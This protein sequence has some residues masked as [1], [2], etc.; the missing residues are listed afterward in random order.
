[1][2]PRV[3]FQGPGRTPSGYAGQPDSRGAAA[4]VMFMWSETSSMGGVVVG[5]PVVS[6]GV[7]TGTGEAWGSTG[8]SVPFG[9]ASVTALGVVKWVPM[10][11]LART[12]L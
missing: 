3:V 10:S 12:H 9:S 1:M 11:R 4:A 2:D 7:A 5:I 8:F 6:L